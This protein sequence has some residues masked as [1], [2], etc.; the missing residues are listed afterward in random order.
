VGPTSLIVSGDCAKVVM[1]LYIY[2]F[3]NHICSKLTKLLMSLPSV[4]FST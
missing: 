1:G 2:H 3:P 4:W